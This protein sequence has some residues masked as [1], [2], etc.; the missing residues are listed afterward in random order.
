MEVV[1]DISSVIWNKTQFE[2]NQSIYYDLADDFLL[3]TD[4]FREVDAKLMIR[5][6]LLDEVMCSFPFEMIEDKKDFKEF[7]MNA[8][9]F[10]A[11]MNDIIEYEEKDFPELKTIPNIFHNHFNEN[12][13]TGYKHLIYEIHTNT[14]NIAFCTFNTIW[15]TTDNLLTECT[16]QKEHDTIIHPSDD[17][18]QYIKRTKRTF[19]H[20]KKHSVRK[21]IT[22]EKG[23]VI[24][25][26]SCY[27]GKDTIKPQQLLDKAQKYGDG[28]KLYN[29]DVENETYVCFVPHKDNLY[30]GF[31]IPAKD[32][33]T[34]IKK[35]F[36][37]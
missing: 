4:I 27:N 15:N 24:S 8:L 2:E 26:L 21:E 19:E 18:E 23:D 25:P 13:T 28:K 34:E 9:K 11:S 12:V 22:S 3:F 10:L 5:Q 37:K 6:E 1:L 17:L 7:R 14:Q 16:E 33:P 31:D 20:N 35:I 32:V 36:L 30:H 29:Y